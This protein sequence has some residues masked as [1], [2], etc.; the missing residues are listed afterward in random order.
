MNGLEI[1]GRS[2]TY[3]SFPLHNLQ[4]D[5]RGFTIDRSDQRLD[6]SEWD[7]GKAGD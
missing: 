2:W 4:D 3:P 6:L 1:G 7:M 5:G